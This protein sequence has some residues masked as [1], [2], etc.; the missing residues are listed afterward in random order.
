MT[1]TPD[2]V[3]LCHSVLLLSSSSTVPLQAHCHF[4]VVNWKA[5]DLQKRIKYRIHPHYSPNWFYNREFIFR[6]APEFICC[7][8]WSRIISP[9][10]ITILYTIKSL[11]TFDNNKPNHDIKEP[12]NKQ[13]TPNTYIMHALSPTYTSTSRRRRCSSPYQSTRMT[14]TSVIAYSSPPFLSLM[15]FNIIICIP[16][17]I[18]LT[19]T[20]HRQK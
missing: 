14:L 11:L 20:V 15:D 2:H 18:V 3:V 17:Y 4:T 5:I 7:Q 6:Y 12:P 1:L 19:G 13:T 16:K 9:T 10:E 8:I